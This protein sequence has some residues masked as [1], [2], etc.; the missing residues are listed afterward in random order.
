[1][2]ELEKLRRLGF[3]LGGGKL[4]PTQG[5]TAKIAMDA[6]LQTTA[7]VNVPALFSTFYSPEVVEILQAPMLSTQIFGEEKRGDWKDTQTLFPV[8]EYVGRTTAYTDFGRGPTSDVNVDMCVRDTYKFQTFIQ[9]G[10]LE[11]ELTAAEK[12]NLLSMK[13]EAAARAI[14][15]DQNLFNF[16]GVAGKTIYGLLN[17]PA[18]PAAITPASISTGASS[19]STAWEDKTGVQIYN[20]ILAL[21]NQIAGASA[22]Y[23]DF[24]SPLKLCVPPS[25]FAYLAK[26][27]DLGVAPVLQTLKGFFPNL[28]ILSI[29]QMEDEDGVCTAMLIAPEVAGK[30]TAAFGFLDKLKTY[31]V[32][33]EHSSMSQ[34]WGSSTTGCLLFRPFAIARMTG[35]QKSED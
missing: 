19:T 27:T 14:Q 4:L 32:V 17:D 18:L 5:D 13:Q 9:C 24:N 20:D 3:D 1:M 21:F 30:K 23:I 2:N 8:A 11:Q 35:I 12:L 6:A 10:D 16:Y 26:V 7:N 33:L 28:E 29:P 34:K 31:R 15:I 25:I 22:G